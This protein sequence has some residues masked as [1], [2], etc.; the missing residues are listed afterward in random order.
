M[1]G[2]HSIRR[3]NRYW[4]GLSLDLVIEQTMMRSI[5]S[6]GGLTRGRGMHESVRETWLSTL[7][8]CASVRS[9]L[10]EVTGA[11]RSTPEHVEVGVSRMKRDTNDMLKVRKYLQSY[12]PFRFSDNDRLV[13]LSSGVVAGPD[14]KVNC[15]MA[16]EF[17]FENQMKWDQKRCRNFAKESRQNNSN[18][19]VSQRLHC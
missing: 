3:F 4:A 9:A 2:F 19:S 13:N 10:S 17:E 16:N 12:N 18:G 6:R 8:D 7:T 1:N 5:K 14:D 11:E 15:E